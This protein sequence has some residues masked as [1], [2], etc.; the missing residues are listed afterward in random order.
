MR[1]TKVRQC[2]YDFYEY[3]NLDEID[4]KKKVD[5]Y[6]CLGWYRRLTGS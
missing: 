6:G 1:M 4:K 3:S 2:F 5:E